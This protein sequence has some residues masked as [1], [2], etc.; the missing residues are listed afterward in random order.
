MTANPLT[1]QMLATLRDAIAVAS[2]RGFER[3]LIADATDTLLYR[4]PG[5]E[6]DAVG[7]VT[8]H[9]MWLVAH[10]DALLTGLDPGMNRLERLHTA[11][12]VMSVVGANLYLDGV[13]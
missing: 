13:V 11:V 4:L 9:A 10:L 6:P 8:M 3:Q 2:G 7:E 12:N 1:D 5:F